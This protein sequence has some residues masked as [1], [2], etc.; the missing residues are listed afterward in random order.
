MMGVVFNF[1]TLIISINRSITIEC[2]FVRKQ[3]IPDELSTS[4]RKDPSVI[5][6]GPSIFLFRPYH[7]HKDFVATSFKNDY[8]PQHQSI[9]LINLLTLFLETDF[10]HV[11]FI[12]KTFTTNSGSQQDCALCIL[13]E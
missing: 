8:P 12:C 13:R 4:C 11:S 3:Y 10:T 7:L 9:V 5:L 1:I 2:C 6:R